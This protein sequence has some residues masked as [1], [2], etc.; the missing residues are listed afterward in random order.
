MPFGWWKKLVF[1]PRPVLHKYVKMAPADQ[2]ALQVVG[3]EPAARPAHCGSSGS[4]EH[5][6]ADFV[7]T[8]FYSILIVKDQVNTKYINS[9]HY[10]S[11]SALLKETNLYGEL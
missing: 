3:P 1:P 7:Q 10:N 11:S 2:R 6:H 5:D 8:G 4:F 9:T